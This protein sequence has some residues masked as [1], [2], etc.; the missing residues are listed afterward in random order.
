MPIYEDQCAAAGIPTVLLGKPYSFWLMR[1]LKTMLT[2]FGVDRFSNA[3]KMDLMQG[4]NL[5]IDL[6]DITEEDE[7][8]ALM[9]AGQSL[10][11]P[12]RPHLDMSLRQLLGGSF[13]SEAL[14]KGMVLHS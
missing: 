11:A 13:P 10:P 5:V 6:F 2:H 1:R 14:R 12:R 9:I 4:C 7:I 3:R 8:P